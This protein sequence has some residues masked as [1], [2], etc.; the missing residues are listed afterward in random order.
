MNVDQHG[1]QSQAVESDA[2]A[3]I[4]LRMLGRGPRRM[5]GGDDS[6]S[7]GRCDGQLGSDYM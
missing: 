7:I 5:R 3:D 1:L 2:I 4:A 6:V